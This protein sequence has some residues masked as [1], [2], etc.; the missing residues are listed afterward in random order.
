M[1]SPTDGT[2]YTAGTQLS[3]PAEKIEVNVANSGYR[4]M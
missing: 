1:G 3:L 4:K 2:V